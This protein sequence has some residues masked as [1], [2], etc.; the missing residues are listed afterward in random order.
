[1]TKQLRIF[2]QKNDGSQS[3]LV[4]LFASDGQGGQITILDNSQDNDGRKLLSRLEQLG[5]RTEII[6]SSPCG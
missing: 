1:M 3:S 2:A 5:I 4:I 6:F